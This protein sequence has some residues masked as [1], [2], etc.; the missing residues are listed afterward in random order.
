MIILGIDPGSI[1][2]GYGL[3]EKQGNKLTHIENGAVYMKNEPLSVKLEMI[4]NQIGEIMN[5]YKP[6]VMSIENI[7]YAKNVQST[8][9]LAHARSIPILLAKQ[10]GLNIYQ[11]TPLEVKKSVTGYGRADKSQMQD[12]VRILLKL[13]ENADSDA[14]DALALAMTFAHLPVFMRDKHRI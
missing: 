4:Y 9:K 3:I 7:F 11:F 6:V 2:L 13:P 14:S 5:I 1:T 10:R 12:M 8:I